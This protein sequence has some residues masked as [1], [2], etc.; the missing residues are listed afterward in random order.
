M[1]KIII[2]RRKNKR[3]SEGRK[4]ER[5]KIENKGTENVYCSVTV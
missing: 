5:K 3:I 2:K 1:C 4:K